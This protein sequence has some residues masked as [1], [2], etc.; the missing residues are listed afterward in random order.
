[1]MDGL[2]QI[3]LTRMG[4]A[5]ES[6][7][8]HDRPA[9]ELFKEAL[10]V[11]VAIQSDKT[12]QAIA[13]GR[14]QAAFGRAEIGAALKR[15]MAC[16]PTPAAVDL[17][18]AAVQYICGELLELSG[19]AARDVRRTTGVAPEDIEK[20]ISWDAEFHQLFP[21]VVPTTARAI[22]TVRLV[23]GKWVPSAEQDY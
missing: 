10:P 4:R 6:H 5:I 13:S 2:I 21:D 14:T 7:K 8:C 22:Q 17:A 23:A 15:R 3:V 16:V 20:V 1:M 12:A 9:L 19:H 11:G 18:A